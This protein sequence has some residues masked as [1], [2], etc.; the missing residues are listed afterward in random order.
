MV[1]IHPNNT[2]LI[3]LNLGYK[4]FFEIYDE[5]ISED[6]WNLSAENR[7]FKL[8]NC[9][10]IYTELLKYEPIKFY[11]D[12]LKK[13][14]PP[15]EG[16]IANEYFLFIRNVLSHFPYFRCWNDIYLNEENAIWNLPKNSSILKFLKKY[17]NSETIKYRLWDSKKKKFTY[18][19]IKFPHSGD[20]KIFMK[21]LVSEKEGMLFCMVLMKQVLESQ[22][23]KT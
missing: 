9:F 4:R 14:R 7:L 6:F 12:Y 16:F 18:I 23:E 13:H 22:L 10:E 17:S 21:D 20:K 19:D 1:N 3:I 15:Q 2:E 8:K 11:M 5:F